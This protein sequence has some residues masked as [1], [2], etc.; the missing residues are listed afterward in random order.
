[1]VEEI[2]EGYEEGDTISELRDRLSAIPSGLD[3][4]KIDRRHTQEAISML[5]AL[6]CAMRPLTLPELRQALALSSK[7][8]IPSLRQLRLWGDLVRNDIEMT[9]RIRSRC[10]GLVEVSNNIVQFIHQSVKDWMQIVDV[11]NAPEPDRRVDQIRNHQ[12]LLKACLQ[13]LLLLETIKGPFQAVHTQPFAS[14]AKYYWLGHYRKAEDGT[15]QAEQLEEFLSPHKPYFQNWSCMYHD[16][17]KTDRG[18]GLEI[19]RWKSI[20]FKPSDPG[21]SAYEPPFPE[22]GARSKGLGTTDFVIFGE[23]TTRPDPMGWEVDTIK[24]DP[25]FPK[26]RIRSNRPETTDIIFSEVAT[27]RDPNGWEI[28]PHPSTPDIQVHSPETTSLTLE[29][30]PP[31]NP[32]CTIH[33][34]ELPHASSNWSDDPS[35]DRWTPF[36]FAAS[37]SLH[38]FLSLQIAHGVDVNIPGGEFGWPLQAAVVADDLSI[39]RLLLDN[40]ADVDAEGGRFGTAMAAA[41]TLQR[42][43]MIALLK[44]RGADV[45]RCPPQS[46]YL[47]RFYRR[48]LLTSM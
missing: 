31:D 19:N 38:S 16:M 7:A 35:S 41:I 30:P 45:E 27:P 1:M 18:A 32:I 11:T 20:S 21:C 44:A 24:P 23:A 4:R 15:S 37:H 9:K 26:P 6:V 17:W 42:L 40:G 14:Y 12:P 36:S 28:G 34:D 29:P 33:I 5:N 10:G 2:F 46:P 22:P 47:G 3:Q 25:S 48:G 13:Y 43:Q 8:P 39:V